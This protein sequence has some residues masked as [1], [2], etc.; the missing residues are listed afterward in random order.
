MSDHPK[1]PPTKRRRVVVRHGKPVS[2]PPSLS[3]LERRL[4]TAVS[5]YIKDMHVEHQHTRYESSIDSLEYYA[6]TVIHSLLEVV[7]KAMTRGQ[8]YDPWENEPVQFP[9]KHAEFLANINGVNDIE[10]GTE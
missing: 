8:I 4:T 2:G 9:E 3:E 1:K 5:N 6:P 10:P 7:E